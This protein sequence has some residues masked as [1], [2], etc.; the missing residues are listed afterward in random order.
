MLLGSR[1]FILDVSWH[2][3][4]ATCKHVEPSAATPHA[5]EPS[6]TWLQGKEPEAT[7]HMCCF[8]WIGRDSED[9]ADQMPWY[10]L[11]A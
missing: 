8:S 9:Q 10:L 6:S 4:C 1:Q 7:Q 2:A 5:P 3:V 11:K